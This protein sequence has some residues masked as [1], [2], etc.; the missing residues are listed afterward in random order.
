MTQICNRL[1]NSLAVLAA[2]L[3]LTGC[4][5]P[6]TIDAD[7]AINGYSYE[8][9]VS[10]RLGY[11]RALK[12]LADGKTLSEKDEAELRSEERK[13][14]GMPGF[15]TFKYV[16]DGRYDL[17]IQLDGSLAENGT[18]IGIPN[19]K[20]KSR[21]NNF[22]T[23]QRTEDGL[24]TISSPQ[25]G[26]EMRKQ[27]ESFGIV[28]KGNV[29]VTVKSGKVLDH[30]AKNQ[31]GLF[32]TFVGSDPKYSWDIHSWADRIFISIDPNG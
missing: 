26:D 19:T 21:K 15:Q 28:P 27:L 2:A 14:E 10:S 25:I 30:N 23:I 12:V 31:S 22:L 16:G 4:L 9:N 3:P 18:A 32:G 5:V 13:S 20:T 24:M 8:M 17:V 1:V 6:E 7:V 11:T 29:Q